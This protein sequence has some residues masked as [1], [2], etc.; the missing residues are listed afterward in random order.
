MGDVHPGGPPCP[1]VLCAGLVRGASSSRYGQSFG[2]RDS[3]RRPGSRDRRTAVPGRGIQ[4]GGAGMRTLPS[5]VTAALTAP[6]TTVLQYVTDR[7]GSF[8]E[9]R[10]RS[11]RILRPTVETA[12]RR[13]QLL[14]R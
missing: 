4:G 2:G 14:H 10:W 3:E 5:H 7:F 9:L 13:D 8:A 6:E 1:P 11:A 12:M